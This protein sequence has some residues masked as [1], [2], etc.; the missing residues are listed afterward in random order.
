[1]LK[2]NFFRWVPLL[3]VL[4]AACPSPQ[5]RPGP[6][7]DGS[8]HWAY[9]IAQPLI[10]PFAPDVQLYYVLGAGISPD[11]RLPSN[12]GDWSFIAW[13]QSR[14]QEI[15]VI[16]K[17][18]GTTST[19]THAQATAPGS[20][21]VVP[22]GWANSPVIFQATIP[23]RPSVSEAQLVAFN[24]NRYNALAWNQAVWNI[25]FDSGPNQLVKWDGTYLGAQ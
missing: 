2:N 16:V 15:Q 14:N 1:M 10:T 7:F 21:L 23:H 13:S 17:Y 19:S 6:T 3:A 9:A 12:L 20:G 24:L 11:G 4:M 18:D 22:A 5:T 8:V 25:H